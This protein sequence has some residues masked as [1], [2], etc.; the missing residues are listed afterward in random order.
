MKKFL[1]IFCALL[2]YIFFGSRSCDGPGEADAELEMKTLLEEKKN[3]KKQFGSDYLSAES[4][5]GFEEKA[6]QK[7]TDF[8]DFLDIY[9][10]DSLDEVFRE[11]A[12]MMIID[13]FLSDS[14]QISKR[15]FR[16]KAGKS[17][18]LNKLLG[19]GPIKGFNYCPFSFD[20]IMVINPLYRT[21]ENKYTGKLIFKRELEAYSIND[22]ITTERTQMQADIIVKKVNKNIGSD[23]LLVWAVR[24]IKN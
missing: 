1:F 17:I 5:Y 11:Q 24:C 10:N 18:T 13:L 3:I 4:L 15:L 14:V 23:T 7:L 9:Y 12:R 2:A 20:S 22:N 19:K 16:V 6:K 8:I 21:D